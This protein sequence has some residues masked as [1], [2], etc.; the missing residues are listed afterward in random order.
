MRILFCGDIV[1]RS[2]REAVFKFLPGW[3]ADL[4][5]D[6]VIANGENAAAGFGITRKICDELFGAGIDVISG[7]N[8][9]WDQREALAFIDAEPRLLRPYNYPRGT[10]GR[11]VGLFD[12]GRGRKIMVLNLMG[13]LFMDPLDDPFASLEQ[14]LA[15]VRVGASV[16]AIVVDF[17]AEATSEKMAMGHVVDGRVSL[18]VGTHTHVPTADQ[19]VLPGGTAYISDIG[20]CGDYDSVIG[21]SKEIPVARFT[22]KLP[23]ERL[24]V[25]T[26]E[27]TLCAVF[28]E[29]DD[30]TGLAQRIEPVRLGGRLAQA[31]PSL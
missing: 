7:G 5:L 27:G 19:V 15:K 31:R 8:H 26:G 17:H 18:C 10:P 24:Q 22:R 25:A 1:G 28:V 16:A 21:M 20:M 14:E 13:R 29:T 12:A 2:G 4:G 11:G 6:F 30:K 3:R 9:S 23:T